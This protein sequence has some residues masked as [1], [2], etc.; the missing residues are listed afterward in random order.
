MCAFVCD[1]S[2]QSGPASSIPGPGEVL[3]VLFKG[4]W[5]LAVRVVAPLTGL[6]LVGSW[7][8]V[9][10]SPLTPR[11]RRLRVASGATWLRTGGKVGHTRTRIHW[12]CFPGWQ[13][14]VTRL[15]LLS[16]AAL[17][18]LAPLWTGLA[19]GLLVTAL[20]ATATTRAVRRK[21]AAVPGPRKVRSVVGDRIRSAI[22]PE[23]ATKTE[24]WF[25]F[26]RQK[27]KVSS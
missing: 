15:V 13:R 25:S 17:A 21:Q 2:C 1:G 4:A 7:K 20:T 14:T 9:S 5:W 6:A 26:L 16:V 8:V 19:L 23:A 3:H 27:V 18:W 11:G 12:Y 24:A 10:G 22:A